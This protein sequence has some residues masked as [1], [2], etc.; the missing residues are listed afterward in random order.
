MSSPF[1]YF[2]FDMLSKLELLSCTSLPA[3]GQ[4][5]QLLLLF[6]VK[7]TDLKR[8]LALSISSWVSSFVYEKPLTF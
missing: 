3:A 5:V 1:Y 6:L 8:P 2:F 7:I 4:Q